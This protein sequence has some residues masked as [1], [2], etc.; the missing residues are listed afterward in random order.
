MRVVAPDPTIEPALAGLMQDVFGARGDEA[1]LLASWRDDPVRF[2]RAAMVGPE[3]IGMTV[4]T[5][6]PTWDPSAH[7]RDF[8]V[9]LE[10]LRNQQVVH[11]NQILVRPSHRQQRVATALAATLAEWV[12]QVGPCAVVGISWAHGGGGNSAPLFEGAGFTALA[13]VRGYY[14]QFHRP[15][16]QRC[17]VC[18]PAPCDCVAVLYLLRP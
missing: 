3:A 17:T 14:R 18:E 15:D 1:E 11:V 2:V 5:L 13:R 4:A 7:E 10:G 12:G 16:G 9:D 8:G 6:H